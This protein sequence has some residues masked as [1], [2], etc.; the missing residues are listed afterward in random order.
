M[1]CQ[2]C[3]DP[4]Q[5]KHKR[6]CEKRKKFERLKLNELTKDTP[7]WQRMGKTE[8]EVMQIIYQLNEHQKL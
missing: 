3:L 5:K 4:T 2:K 1:N 6:G 8:Q 7:L